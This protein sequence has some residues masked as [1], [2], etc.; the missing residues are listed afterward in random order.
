VGDDEIGVGTRGRRR[1]FSHVE[2]A[3]ENREK[4]KI[5]RENSV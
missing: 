4:T 2:S 1:G 5:K 3:R